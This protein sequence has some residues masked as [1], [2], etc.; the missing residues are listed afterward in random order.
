MALDEVR[1]FELRNKLI[2]VELRSSIMLVSLSQSI[3]PLQTLTEFRNTLRDHVCAL[4]EN[5]KSSEE[6]Q[7]AMP[8]VAAQVVKDINNGL[9][10][11]NIAELGSELTQLITGQLMDLL[12][13]TSRVRQLIRK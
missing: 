4:L 6:L 1:F 3:G 2:A 12:N 10:D 13:S 11:Q 9:Q 7:T 5:A 8:N